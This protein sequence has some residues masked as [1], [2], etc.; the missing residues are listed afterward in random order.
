M[1]DFDEVIDRRGTNAFAI[2][3]WRQ[4]LFGGQEP[5]ELPCGPDDV[6]FM[7]LAD[8][9]FGV[10][11][12]VREAIAERLEHPILGYTAML[13]DQLYDAFCDWT[14]SH[15]GWAPPREHLVTSTG[16]VSALTDIA[17]YVLEPGQG[18]LTLSPA[19]GRFD[20]AVQRHGKQL[21]TSPLYRGGS[22]RFE[23]D[24]EDFVAK[25][26]E[27]RIGLFYLCHPHNPTGSVWTT[28]ELQFMTETCLEHG[29]TVLSDEIHCDLLR[30]GL[31]HQPLA[32]LY[33]NEP[34]IITTMSTSKTF[35]LAG[36]GLSHTLI[37]DPDLRAVWARRTTPLVNPLS[38][39]GV[40]AALRE[41]EPWRRDL[42]AYLDEN[43]HVVARY[44]TDNLPDA[45][46]SVPES[47]Y[48]AWIDLSAYVPDELH[49]TRYFAESVGLLLEG[50]DMF[51]A[52]GH[53]HVR[54]NVACPRE[55]LTAG[56]DRLR[57]GL[58]KLD[59]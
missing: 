8:M 6:V 44:L 1:F 21:V 30:S 24:R 40:I 7:W 38:M 26:A 36:L 25:A 15:Y 31:G 47:T 34:R 29:V 56:L 9:A 37:A 2:D 23:L 51:V 33:P 55:T 28:E 54:L 39:A 57:T 13:D 52:D 41:G 4:Y 32:T 35:N 12:C 20:A 58:A 3:G 18:A 59:V 14:Q 42:L 22:G 53:G 17:E 10:A 11:P 46:F 43:F 27:P 19:Y 16:V 48:L 50:G 45:I 49:L 5:P